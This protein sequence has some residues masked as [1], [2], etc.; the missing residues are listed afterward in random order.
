MPAQIQFGLT[1]LP[2]GDEPV[3]VGG[4]GSP[5]K[6]EGATVT[7]KHAQFVMEAGRY[8]VEEL[9]GD[10]VCVNGAPVSGR[11]RLKNRDKIKIGT[12][13]IEFFED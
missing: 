1:G 4:R 3:V 8:W 13:E 12:L 11:V 10:G 7:R 2:L 9:G 5:V 6:V